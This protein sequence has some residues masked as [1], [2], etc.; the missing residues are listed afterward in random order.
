MGLGIFPTGIL[1]YPVT[2]VLD[3]DIIWDYHIY[4]LYDEFSG[5]EL[6]LG[7]GV[8][9]SFNTVRE[10]LEYLTTGFSSFV[11][12][13]ISISITPTVSGTLNIG[14][15]S[16]PFATGVFKQYATTLY[17]GTG[18]TV[19]INWN[20]GM[21][22]YLNFAGV[23]SGTY[24]IGFSNG[25]PGSSYVLMTKQN[26]SG[27]ATLAW[28][29]TQLAWQGGVSGTMTATSG[30]SPVDIFTFMC[31]T[32]NHYLGSFSNNYL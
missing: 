24:T 8:Q 17:S 20:N 29:G 5:V 6:T 1:P 16:A 22:Q 2:P 31:D 23:A 25:I 28:S 7:T 15:L 19:N 18:G 21:S 11:G 30:T 9:G 3:G 27:T 14:T 12:G 13:P 32:S 26:T 10:R 4:A